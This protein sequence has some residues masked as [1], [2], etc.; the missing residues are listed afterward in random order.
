MYS[1]R[2]DWTTVCGSCSKAPKHKHVPGYSPCA[3]FHRPLCHIS[4]MKKGH[5]CTQYEIIWL[6][7]SPTPSKDSSALPIEYCEIANAS[8]SSAF[9]ILSS[10]KVRD[11]NESADKDYALVKAWRQVSKNPTTGTGQTESELFAR[12][13]KRNQE[14]KPT[15]SF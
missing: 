3:F 8:M 10:N 15:A 13:R 7:G 2:L 9:I 5:I 12:I 4:A 6:L 1:C 11:T 14:Y